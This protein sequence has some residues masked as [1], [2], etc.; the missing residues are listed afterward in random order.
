MEVYHFVYLLTGLFLGAGAAWFVAKAR[1]QSPQNAQEQLKTRELELQLKMELERSQA[2]GSDLKEMN[3]ELRSERERILELTN[4]HTRLESDYKNLQEN[5]R[6]QK[7]ELNQIREKFSA[8]FKNMANEIL[9]ENSKKFTSHNKE[10]VDQLL[11]PLGEKITEFEKKVILTNNESMKWNAAL[12]QQVED[13]KGANIKMT[14]E[15]ENLVKA[16]KGDAKAQGNWGERQL[17][18]ILEKVGLKKDVHYSREQNL[19]TEDGNNQRLDFIVNLPDE[20]SLI[21]DSKVSL[22]A[23]ARYFEE[24]DENK[25]TTYLKAHLESINTHIKI[26]GE[27]NYQN[28]Y[29][30]TQPDYVMMFVA[31]EPALT[32]A[33]QQDQ[34]LYEKALE[35]NIVLVSTSTLMATLRTVSYI[36]KQDAQS[37]HALEI[38]RQGGALYDKFVNFSEDLLK[39][40]NSLKTTKT[41]YDAAM[42]KLVEGKDNLVRKTEKLRELGAKTAKN[43]D[44]K[45]LERSEEG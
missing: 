38:A 14:K 13:L 34:A 36:W 19:K 3:D 9:E 28:L 44:Q 7:E 18:G 43:L 23:Y 20:K 10:Q 31:N 39:V 27:K 8:E 25:K 42:N 1:F 41:Q 6:T 5:L 32:I 4:Q 21:I 30:I 16:L 15:A 12:K 37:K 29:D 24:E 17:E 11:K 2:L 40:G 26:L 22:T 33:L 45:L 35:K